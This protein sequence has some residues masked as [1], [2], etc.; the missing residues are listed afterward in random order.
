ML[1]ARQF[2]P[3]YLDWFLY[4]LAVPY[5]LLFGP[6]GGACAT[7]RR[8]FEHGS[9]GANGSS[10]RVHSRHILCMVRRTLRAGRLSLVGFVFGALFGRHGVECGC[11]LGEV[12][13]SEQ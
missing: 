1:R 4:R 12:Q 9:L 6:F 11:R 5:R 2:R 13:P 8:S 10:G 3:F 7:A